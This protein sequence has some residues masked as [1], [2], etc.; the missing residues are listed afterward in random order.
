[1]AAEAKRGKKDERRRYRRF[2]TGNRISVA[3]MDGSAIASLVAIHDLSEDGMQ[4]SCQDFIKRGIMLE[5]TIEEG[6]LKT[7]NLKAR[8]V[9]VQKAPV[10][11]APSVVGLAFMDIDETVR[12][13]LK[14]LEKK[15]WWFG[16]R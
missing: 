11:H 9:W 4:F 1:M 13:R 5:V 2:K 15:R 3:L 8:V 16:A 6:T 12:E 7:L 10:L 14:L